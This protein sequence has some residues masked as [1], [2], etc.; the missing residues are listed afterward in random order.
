MAGRNGGGGVCHS[1]FNSPMVLSWQNLENSLRHLSENW[2][3]DG[4]GGGTGHFFRKRVLSPTPGPV[5]QTAAHH[6]T[7]LE[8]FKRIQSEQNAKP[9][10]LDFCLLQKL[11]AKLRWSGISSS[12]QHAKSAESSSLACLLKQW[13]WLELAF[14]CLSHYGYIQTT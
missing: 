6:W 13:L 2:L 14:K 7:E 3:A 12:L 8:A 11:S 4:L 10:Q 9:L 1:Q 5:S